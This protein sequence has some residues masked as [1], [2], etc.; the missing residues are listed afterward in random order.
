MTIITNVV[1]CFSEEARS[2]GM[3]EEGCVE[4]TKGMGRETEENLEGLPW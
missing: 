1:L 2:C 3:R 4:R